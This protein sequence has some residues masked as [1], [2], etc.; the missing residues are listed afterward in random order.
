MSFSWPWRVRLV[1]AGSAVLLGF[2][3]AALVVVLQ[4]GFGRHDL[5]PF[6]FWSVLHAVVISTLSAPVLTWAWRRSVPGR[7]FA[8]LLAG[9]LAGAGFTLALALGFGSYVLAFSV[10]ILPLWVLAGAAGLL[11]ALRVG[12]PPERDAVIAWG[13]LGAVVLGVLTTV[14]VLPVAVFFLG[15]L[16]MAIRSEREIHLYPDGFTGPTVIL[17]NDSA[18]APPEYDGKARVYRIPSSGVLRTRF[19]RPRGAT[20]PAYFHE[21]ADGTR[22]PIVWST[23]CDPTLPGDP[24]Q[25]CSL[26]YTM[27]GGPSHAPPP[28][29]R[30]DF[31]ARRSEQRARQGEGHRFVDSVV[32]LRS[33]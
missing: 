33:P 13:R 14:A 22:T 8:L 27:R 24:V 7:V 19:P 5:M 9:G 30:A 25:V 28:A 23:S 11:L 2:A 16:L 29:Y 18:G 31:V 1:S 17:F 4:S 15:A 12:P 20:S 3:L 26:G 6:G 21:A 10:P 32:F